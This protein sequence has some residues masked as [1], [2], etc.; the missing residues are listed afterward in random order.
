MADPNSGVGSV[1]TSEHQQYVTIQTS[2]ENAGSG[3]SNEENVSHLTHEQGCRLLQPSI[4]FCNVLGFRRKA[5]ATCE[6]KICQISG[7][8]FNVCLSCV[9]PHDL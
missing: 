5:I 2:G 7:L 4:I 8:F 1:V 9:I 3:N 6:W